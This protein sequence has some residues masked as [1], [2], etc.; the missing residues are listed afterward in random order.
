MGKV[1]FLSDLH[2]GVDARLTSQ[3]RERRVTTWLLS[4]ASDISHLYLLGDIFDHWYEWR[5]VIPAGYS[6][7]W[8]TLSQLVD[9]G[10]DVQVHVGNHDLW[11]YSYITR[12]FGIPIYREPQD[13]SHHGYKIHLAHGDG[14]GPGDKG[15]KLF[16]KIMTNRLAQWMLS[17]LHPNFTIAIMRRLS[18]KSREHGPADAQWMG[19]GREW[20]AQY[21]ESCQ[22]QRER[23]YYIF[24]HRHLPVMHVLK[25]GHSIYV[26]L[27]DWLHYETYGVLDSDG[28]RLES[29]LDQKP[30]IYG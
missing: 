12:E 20:L 10:V 25:D 24:G 26:N 14:L 30:H 4:I 22:Q 18:H 6:R 23:D 1:I 29:H 13:I 7:W 17:R 11:Q 2:L 21:A 19:P 16:K 27:G 3:E 28:L 9:L 5:E 15:Y 8:S